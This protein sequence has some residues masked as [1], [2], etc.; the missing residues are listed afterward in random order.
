MQ[1]GTIK[2][3]KRPYPIWATMLNELQPMPPFL[4][5]AVV[6]YNRGSN[7]GVKGFV[8]LALSLSTTTI[9][10]S[11]YYRSNNNRNNTHSPSPSTSTSSNSQHSSS[12]FREHL[13]IQLP[14]PSNNNN[15]AY[16]A[17]TREVPLDRSR[18]SPESPPAPSP[19]AGI[20]ARGLRSFSP[21][22]H[23]FRGKELGV[24]VDRPVDKESDIEA[25]MIQNSRMAGPGLWAGTKD[26]ITRLFVNAGGFGPS[27]GLGEH[28]KIHQ[29]RDADSIIPIQHA[30]TPSCSPSRM[31]TFLPS[32]PPSNVSKQRCACPHHNPNDPD[33]THD[34]RTPKQ[35]AR[36]KRKQYCF[37]L[38]I[39]FL[40]LYLL[41]SSTFSLV[42]VVSLSSSGSTTTISS[43]TG[44]NTSANI[45]QCVSQYALNAPSSPSSY[46]C[47]SCLP[48]LSSLSPSAISSLSTADVQTATNAVQFCALR[49]VFNDSD[50]NG[51]NS[52]GAGGWGR[53]VKFCAWSG[54][55]CDG[56]GSV[57]SL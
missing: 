57:S 38:F 41:G 30:H 44:G 8:L 31:R 53:D 24:G 39:I 12:K 11:T 21:M 36:E 40:L 32:W 6:V 5:N 35:T 51:Q 27:S 34:T 46:P 33:Y 22:G 48:L 19:W 45:Q 50:S 2:S 54:V 49:A 3:N 47:S 4:D 29:G 17:D 10:M 43:L 9:S 26:K 52:L 42:R 23:S 15:T 18:F 20:G 56:S 14:R 55:G 13:S 1:R 16:R 7:N 28:K 37:L 25:A